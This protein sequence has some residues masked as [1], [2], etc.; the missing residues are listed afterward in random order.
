MRKSAITLG[1]VILFSELGFSA[2]GDWTTYTNMNFVQEMT[3]QPNT[4]WCATT[5]GVF[6]FDL[7]D[8][9]VVKL[10]NVDGLGGNS[11][12][13]V[14]L[15]TSG[16]FWFGADN[17][18][19]S[20]YD[21]QSRSWTLYDDFYD[22]EKGSLKL[23]HIWADGDR[24]WVASNIG[25]S[26]F[27]INH[28]GGEIKETYRRLGEKLKTE[29]EVNCVHIA[30][31]KIWAGTK[32]G[33]AF[34]DKN[35]AFLQ[36]F[37]HWTSFT[38]QT[39]SGLNDD[40][41][42]CITN[43][44]DQ[45][46]IGTRAGVFHFVLSDSS[47]EE[48]V[49]L[50]SHQVRDLKYMNGYLFA[51]TDN[52]VYRYDS[53][54]W[55]TYPLSGLLST[56]LNYLAMD[57]SSNLWVGTQGKGIAR[58]DQAISSW[59]SHIIDG[60]PSNIFTDIEIDYEGTIWCAQYV[61]QY[62]SRVS[63][64]DG[65]KWTAYD[66]ILKPLILIIYDENDK[67]SIYDVRRIKE[68][69]EGTLWFGTWGDGLI[70]KDANGNWTRYNEDNSLLKGVW[71]NTRY[72]VVLGMAVD[73]NGNMWL[74]NFAGR[75]G[76]VLV[77]SQGGSGSDWGAFDDT[78][79]FPGTGVT[80]VAVKDNHLWAG[81]N[82]GEITDFKFEWTAEGKVCTTFSCLQNYSYRTYDVKDG[83][84]GHGILTCAFDKDGTLWVGTSAGLCY[85]SDIYRRFMD[86]PLPDSQGPQ[87]NTIVIDE[88]NRK[89]IGT[90]KG[91]CILQDDEFVGNYYLSNS[92]LVGS[93]INKIAIDDR[94]GDVWIATNSGLSK[95]QYGLGSA[96]DDLSLVTVHPNP[97]VIKDKGS[98][99][100]FDRLPYQSKIRIYTPAGE[101]VKEIDS[102]NQ[103]DG[104][105]QA[106]KLV[107]GGIYLFYVQN[108]EGKSAVG[109]IALIRE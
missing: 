22:S 31:D 3:A 74:A 41:V 69:P 19:L 36:D 95:Y 17:G 54:S 29:I 64:L 2:I 66:S 90:I 35:D 6:V 23:N 84:S 10:T 75:D 49:G 44:G 13:S 98:K 27:L 72:V 63:S 85:Y 38:T 65:G 52:G 39:S 14:A 21:P 104:T 16:A 46:Y 30:G 12:Y 18:T 100:T 93:Y 88:R 73:M 71:N 45:I 62:D 40:F 108:Q 15:D 37:T 70:K 55:D 32:E 51:A 68:Y 96:Q 77:V 99:L 56:D 92:K 97:F 78:L 61:G 20:K 76:R 53:G 8:S 101:L 87:V 28:N 43:I 48:V 94:T 86:Y 89:W 24:L 47:W 26:L 11:V 80:Y 58:Y 60:P 1:I 107:A 5:G 83:L 91:F 42:Y 25:I 33:I 102:D 57:S 50:G 105:N 103:W 9:S 34:A 7:Q 81:F 82:L 79:G 59:Q 109:K 106:G 4:I 67:D